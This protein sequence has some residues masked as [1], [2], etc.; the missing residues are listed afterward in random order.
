MPQLG[1]SME[2]MK[3]HDFGGGVGTI[4]DGSQ[5]ENPCQQHGMVGDTVGSSVG[6]IVG[7][8]VGIPVGA[9]GATLG[10]SVGTAVG[11]SESASVECWRFIR[12]LSWN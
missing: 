4:E 2:H 7:K 8:E 10:C 3:A 11:S 12:S 6:T 9:V 1:R 5:L